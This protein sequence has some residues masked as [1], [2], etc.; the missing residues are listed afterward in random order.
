MVV[1]DYPGYN[2]AA[3]APLSRGMQF[4]SDTTPLDFGLAGFGFDSSATL[5]LQPVPG[6]PAPT[7]PATLAPAPTIV[8]PSGTTPGT[9]LGAFVLA[10][11]PAESEGLYVLSVT[12]ADGS[13]CPIAVTIAPA[14]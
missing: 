6:A 13:I 4:S 10:G 2:A 1:L 9:I 8:D 14:A 7:T 5:D 3:D 11:T 12:N